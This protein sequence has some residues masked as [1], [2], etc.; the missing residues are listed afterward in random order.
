M[1]S[2]RISFTSRQSGPNCILS[3]W[4]TKL[5]QLKQIP[6]WLGN[7]WRCPVPPLIPGGRQTHF[8]KKSGWVDNRVPT[9]F[10]KLSVKVTPLWTWLF[11]SL[12]PSAVR[13]NLFMN[14]FQICL[15]SQLHNRFVHS[16]QLLSYFSQWQLLTVACLSLRRNKLMIWYYEGAEV[17]RSALVIHPSRFN[18]FTQVKV[19]K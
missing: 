9:K 15:C 1:G 19:I 10:W 2:L 7:Q 12:Q 11:L 5:N 8:V 16:S 4:W 14:Y 18:F 6:N 3:W 17:R 13:R